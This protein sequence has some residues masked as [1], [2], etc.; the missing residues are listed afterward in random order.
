MRW[1]CALISAVL[2]AVLVAQ[3]ARAEPAGHKLNTL[4]DLFAALEVCWVPPPIEE[5]R[6][7]MEITVQFAL[8]R[9]GEPMGPPRVTYSAQDVPPDVRERYYQSFV[10]ALERCT[11]FPLSEGLAGAIAGRPIAL[12]VK[13]VR[14]KAG[15]QRR[16]SAGTASFA[17]LGMETK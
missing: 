14:T 5:A 3:A 13:D 6:L 11:P 17:A 10:A 2:V 12:R 1:V 16:T 9:S 4:N 15:P 8:K 7:G